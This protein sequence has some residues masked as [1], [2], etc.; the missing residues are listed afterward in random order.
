MGNCIIYLSKRFIPGVIGRP[1]REKSALL[2]KNVA[3]S[4]NFCLL[5]VGDDNNP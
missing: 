4:S 2:A 3:R 1:G 5:A